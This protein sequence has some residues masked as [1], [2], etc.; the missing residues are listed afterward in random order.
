MHVLFE[1]QKYCSQCDEFEGVFNMTA[2]YRKESEF[3]SIYYSDS[4]LRFSDRPLSKTTNNVFESK[5]G[6]G[7]A[8]ALISNGV[9]TPRL[10]YVKNLQKYIN[11]TVFRD[12]DI[13]SAGSTLRGRKS[14][15]FP[16][17]TH[18]ARTS[19]PRSFLTYSRMI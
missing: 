19:S 15:F 6:T 7:L 4:G 1:S 11:I 3:I 5:R 18:C 10:T 16:L 2:S 9:T 14:F 12:I 8:A 17:R 13:P